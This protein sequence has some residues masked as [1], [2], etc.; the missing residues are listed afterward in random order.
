MQLYKDQ[1]KNYKWNIEK[2]KA[3]R[4]GKDGKY[5]TDKY[6]EDI[7]TFDIECTSAWLENG[8]VIGY[9]RYKHADRL[10]CKQR[11][12]YWNNLEPLAL[13]YLWQCS[14]ND[15]V[16]YGR[17]L[18]SF[19]TLLKDLPEDVHIII[20]VHNL[21]YEFQFLC[22]VLTWEK[23]FA[24][25]PHKPIKASSEEFP[26]IEFRCS[27]MLTRLSL[28][29]WGKQIGVK[30]AVGDLDYD[31]VRTPLTPLTDQ[32][33]HYGEQDC[34]VVYSGI[35]DYLKRYKKQRKIPLTQ[36]GTVRREVKNIITPNKFLMRKIKRLVP[37]SADEYKR[38]QRIFSGG[39]THSNQMYSGKVIEG[40]LIKHYDFSSSY[41]TVMLCEKYPMKP[42]YYNG[43][44]EIPP[45]DEFEDTAFIFYLEFQ[46]I[47]SISF[48]TY[49]QSS[50]CTGS[51]F[52]YDNGRVLYAD[53]LEI[54]VTEQ[55]YITIRNN[56]AWKKINVKRVWRCEKEYLPRDFLKYILELYVNKTSLKD[57]P[58]REDLYLQSKQY[59]N[60]LFGMMVTALIQADV[61]F[62]NGEWNI[63]ELTKEKVEKKLKKLSD[64]HDRERRYFLS[65]SWGCWVTAYA[66]RNL[67]KCIESCDHDMIY[68]DTDSIFVRGVHDFTWYNKEITE[69]IRKSCIINDLD[70]ELT[71]PKTPKGK[72]KPL[73]IFE[74]EDDCIQFKTM[75]AKR[76]IER[77]K[78]DKQ[79]HM[80]VSG[81]NKAAVELLQDNINNFDED[82]YFDMDAA[83]V[84]KKLSTYLDDIPEVIYPD[85][86]VSRY[87]YGINMR[88]TG[89][90]MT[91]TDEY[92][93]LIK[94]ME[95]ALED[96][97]EAFINHLRGTWR[98]KT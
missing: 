85:G 23:V 89:Y 17:E 75:G 47:E 9:E 18:E 48:N 1:L 60:S 61:E 95:Y 51:G 74:Q 10:D 53:T 94:Y 34:L 30:K 83:C 88:N 87:K 73:G 41:P 27:Y 64:W 54:Y 32:E 90:M 21:A 24:R 76:Y 3:H 58:G 50:K 25:M 13:C 31:I 81:I 69:K 16:F 36:T 46:E 67:W 33:L 78:S 14:V 56:Y 80:T 52:R 93:L 49:I 84:K 68:C 38:L 7:I 72:D 98:N 62:D 92:K 40:E 39:Y 44:N 79:L 11:Q 5:K 63:K 57:V 28:D 6:L 97:P 37:K 86:Y 65:Y 20:W 2:I 71:H 82:F 12:E 55:D 29:S 96:L 4:K 26:F 91:I 15:N 43:I 70:F 8:S 45:D 77:R 35:K 19:I 59:I 22:N 66:R 42:W